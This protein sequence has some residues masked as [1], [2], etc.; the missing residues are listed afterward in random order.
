MQSFAV[1]Q[2]IIRVCTTLPR[3]NCSNHPSRFTLQYFFHCY[4]IPLLFVDYLLLRPQSP[5]SGF[6][7]RLNGWRLV[8][9]SVQCSSLPSSG[10]PLLFSRALRLH[11]MPSDWSVPS[12][13]KAPD[14]WAWPASA[15]RY[16]T[17]VFMSQG[18][19]AGYP[20]RYLPSVS[21]D[22]SEDHPG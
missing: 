7:S 13:E 10:R 16:P 2:H 22:V 19:C 1:S 8:G 4:F 3:R 18:E 20:P 9:R 17:F 6:L 21:E 11:L 12:G 5:P 14:K 15:N